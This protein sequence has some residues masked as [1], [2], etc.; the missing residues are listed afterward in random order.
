M[1]PSLE[2]LHPRDSLYETI[3][4]RTSR[5]R[6]WGAISEANEFGA[7]FGARF[8]RHFESG[9]RIRGTT[10]TGVPIELTIECIDSNHLVAFRWR[11]F[12][13]GPVFDGEAPLTT[14][15]E[16]TLE[17]DPEGVVLTV[18]ESGFARLP[19]RERA[20]AFTAHQESWRERLRLLRRYVEDRDG[21]RRALEA[22]APAFLPR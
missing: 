20:R 10:Q 18:T 11:P 14:L 17:S 6:A 21:R 16:L 9:Q 22:H 1:E 13:V 15:V 7:W 8:D 4:L 19:R 12:T 3:V 5:G 2:A